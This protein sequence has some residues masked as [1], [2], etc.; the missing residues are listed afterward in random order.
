MR[1]DTP[2]LLTTPS[3]SGKYPHFAAYIRHCLDIT[4]TKGS[5]G[6]LLGFTSGTRVADWANAK[7]GRPSLESCLRLAHIT[8]DDPL[9]I[10]AMAGHDEAVDLLR[11]FLSHR[12]SAP[13]V[14]LAQPRTKVAAAIEA[15]MFVQQQLE[16]ES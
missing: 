15:L 1:T 10:L 13:D 2:H 8:G 11:D 5:L 9:D 4:G 6:R 7:G 14:M 12:T 16:G 3:P